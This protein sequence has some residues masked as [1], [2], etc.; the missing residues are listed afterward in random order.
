MPSSQ[1]PDLPG[2][3]A[4]VGRYRSLDT[5]AALG[6]LNSVIDSGTACTT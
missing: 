3:R 5:I 2:R 4:H 1:A 6:T